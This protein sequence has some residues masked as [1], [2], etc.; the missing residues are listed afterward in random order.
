MSG[1][2]FSAW[3]PGTLSEPLSRR[4]RSSPGSMCGVTRKRASGEYRLESDVTQYDTL[5]SG[6]VRMH[7]PATA[8]SRAF[9]RRA[10]RHPVKSFRMSLSN[11]G[12]GCSHTLSHCIDVLY[13]PHLNAA[14]PRP[15]K[16]RRDLERLV[17]I[18][19]FDQIEAAQ[20]LLGFRERSVVH[21]LATV[22]NADG[23]RGC[24][25][26]EHPRVE[27]MTFD[28]QLVALREASAHHLVE[29][30]FGQSIELSGIRVD[31][32]YELHVSSSRKGC[33]WMSWRI[34]FA[35]T[36]SANLPSSLGERE[37]AYQA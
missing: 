32:N 1:G 20:D 14:G 27:E 18:L 24:R 35:A 11:R 10:A 36:A 9:E 26:L 22:A 12:G 19:G 5:G 15:R 23:L 37:P 17:H 4:T 8:N 34:T 28:A 30:S 33:E 31:E 7:A 16:V 21:R 29:L 2:A 6:A 3:S 13:G 25:I